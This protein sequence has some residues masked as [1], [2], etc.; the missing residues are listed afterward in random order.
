MNITY[1]TVLDT[2]GHET[3]EEIIEQM[4]DII[5]AKSFL[6]QNEGERIEYTI[7]IEMIGLYDRID[8]DLWGSR[9]GDE[10]ERFEV[11]KAVHLLKTKSQGIRTTSIPRNDAEKAS[12]TLTWIRG[13]V[14]EMLTAGAER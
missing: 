2:T 13:T 10:E 4:I 8:S 9:Y 1:G 3:V 14:A 5:A 11:V 12:K 6:A 7:W